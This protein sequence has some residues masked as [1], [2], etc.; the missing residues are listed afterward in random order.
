M[1]DLLKDAK[2]LA[3]AIAAGAALIGAIIAY[4]GVRAA[5]AL[6]RAEQETRNRDLVRSSL[7]FLTGGTQKRTVGLAL[8]RE[9]LADGTIS[10]ATAISILEGQAK[11]LRD[12]KNEEARRP[13]EQYNLGTI[14]EILLELR[15]R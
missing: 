12:P 2:V 7:E 1:L 13:I 10:K 6:K 3:A 11:H 15:G 9:R 4:A 14:E 8:L 5:N